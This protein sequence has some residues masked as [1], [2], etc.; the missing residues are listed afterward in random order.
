[1][2]NQSGADVSS[3]LLS[4]IQGLFYYGVVTT[5]TDSTHFAAEMLAGYGNG[6]FASAS[7][8]DWEVY[9]LW[10]AGAAGAAPQGLLAPVSAY[11]SA[12]GTF[13]HTAFASGTLAVGDK[14]LLVHPILAM[15][16]TKADAAA[17]GAVTS[18]DSAAQ[19]IKQII[20]ELLGTDGGWTNLSNSA[21]ASLDVAIQKIAAVVGMDSTNE[22]APV[23]SGVAKTTLESA[24][25]ALASA[26]GGGGLCY[27]GTVTTATST[28]AFAA[29][30]FIQTEDDVFNGYWLYVQQ[31][32]DAAP[33]REWRQISD[34]TGATGAIVHP[35]FTAQLATGDIVLAVHPVIHQIL[36]MQGGP[37]SVAT[38]ASDNQAGLD[39]ATV[40]T[41]ASPVTLTGSIQYVYS[42]AGKDRPWYFAGGFFSQ[43][44][45]AW[46]S[47]VTVDI[48]VQLTVDGT[49]W[50]NCWNAVQLAAA[51]TSLE[52]A[53]PHEANTAL[54]GGIPRGFWVGAGVGVRVGIVQDA[55]HDGWQVWSHNFV[56]GVSGN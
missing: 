54:L 44:S 7:Y 14:V 51:S 8:S 52:L 12:T 45:G 2:V 50:A 53:V 10:D 35:A 39:F 56:D 28:T 33:Q 5:Y 26:S 47:G 4:K 37:D 31:A 42:Q 22:F 49:N 19:Y 34:S 11:V 29:V 1:M 21:V 36:T 20:N 27:S 23:I 24:L 32:D 30:N 13:T 41:I 48:N 38:L 6:F 9:A 43:D 25:E 16:G 18:A 17:A 40:Q 15:I 3:E 46:T 55:E